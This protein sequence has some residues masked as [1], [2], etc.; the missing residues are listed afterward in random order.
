SNELYQA[1][2]LCYIEIRKPHTLKELSRHIL[3]TTINTPFINKVPQY[4]SKERTIQQGDKE[5]GTKS[6]SIPIHSLSS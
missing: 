3:D 6:A 1:C 2:H 4:L 5:T